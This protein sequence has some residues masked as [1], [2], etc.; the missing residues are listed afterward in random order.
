MQK[1][2]L[3]K[4]KYLNKKKLEFA[5]FDYIL[6]KDERDFFLARNIKHNHRSYESLCEL[7]RKMKHYLHFV[8]KTNINYIDGV[9]CFQKKKKLY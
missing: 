8:K 5:Q 7:N 3:L 6:C 2:L 1:L 9:K 4:I